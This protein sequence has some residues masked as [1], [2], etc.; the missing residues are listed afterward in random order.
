MVD[1]DPVPAWSTLRRGDLQSLLV[2]NALLALAY[3]LSAEAGLLFALAHGSVSLVWPPA[4]IALAALV[5]WGPRVLPGVAVGALAAN[6]SNGDSW[7]FALATAL[8]NP[9]EALVGA[10]LLTKVLR[11]RC[12]MERVRDIIGL[13]FLAAPA[14]AVVAA[15]FGATALWYLGDIPAA[16][17][18]RTWSHWW[19]GDSIGMII[20]APVVFAMKTHGLPTKLYTLRALEGCALTAVAALGAMLLFGSTFSDWPALSILIIPLLTIIAFRFTFREVAIANLLVAAGA[21]FGAGHAFGVSQPE[22]LGR[23]LFTLATLLIVMSLTTQLLTALHAQRNRTEGALHDSEL[24]HRTLFE[25]AADAIMLMRDGR[26]V[27]CNARALDVYGCSREQILGA[28]P[29]EF[30]PPVQPDG[31]KSEESA[32]EKMNLALM[33]KP[34]RFE[35]EHCRWDKTPFTAEVSLN[36]LELGGETHLQAIV[37]DISEHKRARMALHESERK[38]RE[39]V[40]SAN[41]I[42]LRWNA[43][44]RI[45]FLNEYGLRFFGY[46]AE[47]IIGRHVV[48]SITPER[49]SSGR[50]LQQLIELICANPSAFEQNTNENM[51][52]NGECVW[53]S[54][55]NK[56]VFDAQARVSEILSIGTDITERLRAESALRESEARYRGLFE[57]SPTSLWEEDFSEVKK[58]IDELRRSGV[59]D[60]QA[61]FDAHPGMLR[62]CAAMAKVLDVNRATLELLQYEH[63]EDLCAHL[64]QV[65]RDDSYDLFRKELVS[66]ASG[67]KVFQAEAINHNSRGEKVHVNMTLAIVPGH[68]ETWS[69]VFVSFTDISS[70]V[71]AEEELRTL[72]AVLENR[73]EQRTAELALAKERAESADRLKSAF[74]AAMSHELRTPLNSILGFTGIVLQGLPGPLNTEQTKQLGMVQRSARHLLALINDVLDLS[75]IEA[76]QLEVEAKPF[77]AR[78]SVEN[79][80][81][82]VTPLAEKKG[83]TLSVDVSP[84]VGELTNDRRRFEQILINLINNGLKFTEKGLVHVECVVDGNTLVTRVVDT[85]MGIKPEDMGKLFQAFQQIDVGLTRNHEGTG[86]GLNICKRLIEKMGGRI[87]VESEWGSGS[88]FSFTLPIVHD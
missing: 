32:M 62:Q 21:V 3:F 77:N 80:V 30:S 25:T 14:S 20:V 45:T 29:S 81:R 44:G 55:T 17:Y 49:E 50:D 1:N 31:R 10:L 51:R 28:Y 38:Y 58:Y 12:A 18:I 26:F 15:T 27:D 24:K 75:K 66:L 83:L 46:S 7:P 72:N 86:L 59:T 33:G 87:W 82:L 13:T 36:R 2:G 71:R 79:V 11:F 40:E 35:W 22:I 37:R 41:S 53:V 9:A 84:E 67:N 76:G 8:G 19:L 68:E 6:L 39:L 54:W 65:F 73:V 61:Y 56:V 64:S 34:Q 48:G 43:D 63:R 47:E 78:E 70:R 52:R 16:A 23:D 4:G 74:L 85:G 57:D 88:T 5:V 42:I 69:R 60:L